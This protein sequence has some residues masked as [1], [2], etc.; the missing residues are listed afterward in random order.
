M[1]ISVI[2]SQMLQLFLILFIGWLLYRTGLFNRDTNQRLS[3]L[4]LTVSLP[5]KILN[6]VI[7]QAERPA[8]NLV[9]M[10]FVIAAAMYVLLPLISLLL[11][12]LLRLPLKQQGMYIFMST[13]G[14]IGFMG[15]PLVEAVFGSEAVFYAAIFNIM[16][17]VSC[18]SIGVLILHY[19]TGEKA[20]VNW[21]S[22]VTP[23]TI[24][25]LCSIIIYAGKIQVPEVISQ[26]A[27]TLGA[28]TTPMAMMLIGSTLATM[29]LNEVFKD[30]HTYLFAVVRQIFLPLMFWP[31]LSR[32]IPDNYLLGITF[33]MLIMPVANNSV[34]MALRYHADEQLAAKTVFITTIMSVATIPLLLF[35][36]F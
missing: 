15:F 22:L 2:L 29:N 5:A 4:I 18:F 11:V 27:S 9:I 3:R 17:N 7:S 13:Y 33:L 20:R 35:L 19:Q 14:N 21:K 16:F 28:V 23:A 10:T 6:S 31:L 34:M 8:E 30:W 25:C 12:K 26:T 32:M 24:S 1:E 36:C